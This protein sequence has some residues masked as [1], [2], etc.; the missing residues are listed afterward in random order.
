MCKIW[1]NK[2]SD[3]ITPD[4]LRHGLRNPLYSEVTGV[5]LNGGEP[6]LRKDLGEIAKVLFEELPK[7]RNISLITNAYNYQEVIARIC[8]VGEAVKAHNGKLDVMVSLDGYGEIHDRV[9]GK[10]GNFERAQK[11][12]DFITTS[13]LVQSVRIGCT[14]IKENVYGLS[15]LFE[16]CQDRDLYIKYRIGIPHQRLYTENFTAPYTLSKEEKYHVAEFLEGLIKHYEKNDHQNFFYRSL[17]DQLIYNAPR[18]AG[19]DWQHRGATIT[20][21]G[22]LL[23][24]AVQSKALGKISEDNSEKIY[25]QNQEHLH[26]IIKNKCS[27][28]NHDYVGLPPRRYHAK[29]LSIKLLRKMGVENI[30]R[31]FYSKSVFGKLRRQAQ[32]SRRQASLGAHVPYDTISTAT[33]NSKHRVLICGWYGTETLG[34]KAILAGV[35][36]A[37]RQ[38]VGNVEFTLVALNTYISEMTRQQMPELKKI[39]IVKPE[40]GIRLASDMDLVVFGGGPL[41]A[42]DELAEMELIFQVARAREIPT[43]IAGCGVGPTGDVWHNRSLRRI[44]DTATLRIYRDEKS[45][46]LASKLGIDTSHD[47]VAED[48]AFTWLHN[49]G[50]LCEIMPR[51]E[52]KTLLLGLRDFPYAQ[53]ARHLSKTECLTIRDHYEQEVVSALEQLAT[54]HPDLCIKPLP[55]C[56]NHFGD[57]D[58]WFYRRLFRGNTQLQGRIDTSLLNKELTPLEYAAAFRSS[59]VAITMRF[60]SLVFAL[61]LEVPAVAIDYTLGKGKVDA[62]AKRFNVPCQ[63][64]STFDANF[65]VQEVNNLLASPLPQASGFTPSFTDS[66]KV[67]LPQLLQAD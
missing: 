24:C 54:E 63:S 15:D 12:I 34:D 28:C 62:L 64:L 46:D 41:M 31:H 45:R 55:M 47:I 57:D 52:G 25:F 35:M 43:M 61:G 51:K 13:P 58:R 50:G 56:T 60:H 9:R 5:G 59:D 2:K 8:D 33:H 17:I 4:A 23:Y 1:E 49:Q 27:T 36:A 20:S 42:I 19:C 14:I 7:L 39:S 10:P 65:I 3:D 32:Y 66:V 6:T 21:K 40:E 44:L 48:P 29:Q 22:E 16:F 30:V 67:H 26:G 37:I 38:S 11:V 18:K 53:Y